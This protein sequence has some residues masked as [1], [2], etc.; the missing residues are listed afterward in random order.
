MLADTR[1]GLSVGYQ[2][3]TVSTDAEEAGWDLAL[4]LPV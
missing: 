2:G 4:I 1:F 3:V